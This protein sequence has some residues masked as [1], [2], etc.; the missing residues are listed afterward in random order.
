MSFGPAKVPEKAVLDFIKAKPNPEAFGIQH[1][2]YITTKTNRMI[3]DEY[4]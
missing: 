4:R 1:N 2:S 3:I